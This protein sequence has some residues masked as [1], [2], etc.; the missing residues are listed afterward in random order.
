MKLRNV[1]RTWFCCKSYPTGITNVDA[2]SQRQV[3]VRWEPAVV[4]SEKQHIW[5]AE[6]NEIAENESKSNDQGSKTQSTR[7]MIGWNE[8]TD[9]LVFFYI[10]VWLIPFN[11][12]L[13]G[14]FKSQNSIHSHQWS[15]KNSPRTL[16]ITSSFHRYLKTLFFP[17]F[18]S[19]LCFALKLVQSL[20]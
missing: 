5:G 3:I 20:N 11:C 8:P 4:S 7:Q 2:V 10:H 1:S 15:Q 16:I 6:N 9:Q 19:F 12:L 17:S 14:Y 13:P 18:Y